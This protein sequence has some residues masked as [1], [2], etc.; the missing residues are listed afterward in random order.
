MNP[1]FLVPLASG[2]ACMICGILVLLREP[3]AATH[4]CTGALL[5]GAA[6]WGLCE[7]LWTLAPDPETALALARLSV[8]GWVFVGPL[9]LQLFLAHGRA[10]AWVR[11]VLPVAWAG[12]LAA[13]GI[14][15]TTPWLLRGVTPVPWGWAL[16]VGPAFGLWFVLA[17]TSAGAG[18]FS[19]LRALRRN[20]SPA[21]ARQ[22]PWLVAAAGTPLL[23]G[24]TTDA[25]LPLLGVPVP[26][27]GVVSFGLL[28][29]LVTA[30]IRRFGWSIVTPGS[31]AGLVLDALPEGVALVA[32]DGRV[33]LANPTLAGLVGRPG[34]ALLGLPI[35]GF[36]PGLALGGQ[37]G[38]REHE[39][40]LE[41]AGGERVPVAISTSPLR[42]KRGSAAGLVLVVRDLREV[43]TLRTRLLTSAR[44]AAVG[45]LAAGIAH[46]IN[47]PLAYINANLR[48]L[49][50]QWLTLAEAWQ[51]EREKPRLEDVFEDGLD[52]LDESLEGVDR[53][54]AIVRDVR[55]FSHAGAG[56][57]ERLEPHAL[58]ERALRVADP[59]LRRRATV[60][61]E[62]GPVPCVEGVRRELEQVLLNLVLN[63]AQ[64]LAEE[65]TIRVRT[66]LRGEEVVI[67]VADDGCGIAPELL[68]RIFDPFFTTRPAGEGTGLGLSISHE[69]VRRHG[70]R[71]EVRS[72]P[73]R[74]SEF[75]VLLPAA[76]V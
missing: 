32:T 10:P 26:R 54:A 46:E 70:G 37:A 67:S 36:L 43:V 71:I 61:R 21:A 47:N 66:V 55:A 4:R 25:L 65:G 7:A 62:L 30:T 3:D 34:D 9:A 74:G 23:F 48:A 19:S 1:W 24:S 40:E 29:V 68:E 31:F 63:A 14:G 5:L 35:A 15:W 17:I 38:L 42:D 56:A 18:L 13:L 58:V 57:R 6:W 41:R 53:T 8:P 27:L 50:D 45:D 44:L 28:G 11:G 76:P 72:E 69:I 73:G 49:R 33:R 75:L 59:H 2:L 22:S 12:S 16:E 52:M 51:M 60:V 39:C 64:A 20:A